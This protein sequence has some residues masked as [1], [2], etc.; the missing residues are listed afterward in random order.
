MT[1]YWWTVAIAS[2]CAGI[3]WAS[4]NAAQHHGVIYPCGACG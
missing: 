1:T 2:L 4:A 3:L